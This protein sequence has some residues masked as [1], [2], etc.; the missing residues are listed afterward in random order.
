MA[1]MGRMS[2]VDVFSRSLR[3]FLGRGLFKPLTFVK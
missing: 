3:P 2:L 1:R